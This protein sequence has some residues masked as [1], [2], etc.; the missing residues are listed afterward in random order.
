MADMPELGV[1]PMSS[2][3]LSAPVR[4]GLKDLSLD[5]MAIPPLRPYRRFSSH[6]T[7]HSPQFH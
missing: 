2:G 6:C 3:T 1:A 4:D 5:V 7:G